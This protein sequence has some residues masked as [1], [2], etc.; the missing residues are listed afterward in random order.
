MTYHDSGMAQ[1]GCRLTNCPPANTVTTSPLTPP[2]LASYIVLSALPIWVEIEWQNRATKGSTLIST[3]PGFLVQPS[4]TAQ[5]PNKEGE[6][7]GSR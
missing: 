7:E 4:S 3:P 5:F 6:P 1:D 2:L